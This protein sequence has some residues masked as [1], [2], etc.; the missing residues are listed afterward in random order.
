MLTKIFQ[1]NLIKKIAKNS[2]I[3]LTGNVIVS[4]LGIISFTIVARELGP[5]ILAIL[6]LSQTYA[7]IV[8]DL[9]NIQTWESMVKFGSL[10]LGRSHTATIIKTNFFLDFVSAIVAC[11]FANLML[12]TVAHV[13][14]WDEKHLNVISLYSFSILF[15]ITTFTIGIPR[16]FYKFSVIAK[17]QVIVACLKLGSVVFAMYYFSSLLVYVS[18][19]LC[20]EILT[21][22]SLIVLSLGVLKKHLGKKWWKNNFKIDKN[23][24]KFIWWTN[25]RTIVRIPVK[26]LD[27]IVISSIISLEMVGIYKVYK[28]IAGLL[29]RVGE[30][31]SQ[32]IYPEYTKL[33]GKNDIKAT[34]NATKKT[35]LL[36]SGV[37]IVGTL[38]L[39]LVSKFIVVKLFG[40]EYTAHIL[41]LYALLV[42]YGAK[43]ITS[44]INSL[45][46]A[47]GFAKYSF[48][49]VVLTNAVYLLSVIIFCKHYGIYGLVLA[50]AIQWFLNKGLKILLLTKYSTGWGKV[51]R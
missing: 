15:N 8:N 45:F 24:I 37:G 47:A 34:V 38:T 3:I 13:M 28:E 27:M 31:I 11:A 10:G 14:G 1:D 21:N 46:I 51:I 41:A 30:P 44:P 29:G 12:H 40:I 50:F 20:A 35:M 22:L 48:L 9:L 16:F 7:L 2:G 39:L 32:A 49:I 18:I 19:F 5:E 6:V 43:L 26:H 25:L 4:V 17:I 33:L 23:Q 36:L 42:L